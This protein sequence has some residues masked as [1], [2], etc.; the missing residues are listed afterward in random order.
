MARNHI[1][2]DSHWKHATDIYFYIFCIHGQSFK[3]WTSGWYLMFRQRLVSHLCVFSISCRHSSTC[4]IFENRREEWFF[5]YFL[6]FFSNSYRLIRMVLA[7]NDNNFNDFKSN[8][9]KSNKCLLKNSSNKSVNYKICF[10]HMNNI[11]WEN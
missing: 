3:V 11:R 2:L 8:G 10:K 7:E 6:I 9:C 4:S 1:Q 5:T